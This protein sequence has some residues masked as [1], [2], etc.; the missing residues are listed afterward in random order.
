[1]KVEID[2]FLWTINH[3]MV[4]GDTEVNRVKYENSNLFKMW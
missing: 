3:A 1:M 4:E 2:C